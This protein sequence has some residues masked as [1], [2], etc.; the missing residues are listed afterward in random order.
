MQKADLDSET[1]STI[2][3]M[4]IS[5]SR[6]VAELKIAVAAQLGVSH[7][8]IRCVFERHGFSLKLLDMPSKT[9]S[10][11]GFQKTNKVS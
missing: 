9:L 5:P 6:T 7:L 11:E 10:V 3:S 2:H 8:D 1:V 4:R